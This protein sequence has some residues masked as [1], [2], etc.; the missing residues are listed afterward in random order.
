M[1]IC[2]EDEYDDVSRSL[3]R[4]GSQ[5]RQ[6]ANGTGKGGEYGQRVGDTTVWREGR[7]EGS[8]KCPSASFN[9]TDAGD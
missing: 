3:R 2:E 4:E 8:H 7:K 1:G 6:R 5:T 9:V